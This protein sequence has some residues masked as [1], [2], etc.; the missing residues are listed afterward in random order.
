MSLITT[1]SRPQYARI[2]FVL[3]KKIP[4]LKTKQKRNHIQRII[5]TANYYGQKRLGS[6]KIPPM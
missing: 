4:K 6:E 2:Q 1:F 5:V 3:I